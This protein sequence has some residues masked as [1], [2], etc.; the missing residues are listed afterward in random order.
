MDEN[1][2]EMSLG[3]FLRTTRVKKGLNQRKIAESMGITP[4]Y[5]C[6]LE[7][8][9]HPAATGL[10]QKAVEAYL[11]TEEEK[12]TFHNLMV[13]QPQT[14]PKIKTLVIA[15]NA[16]AVLS[17]L[18]ALSAEEFSWVVDSALAYKKLFK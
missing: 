13:R 16:T 17:A 1:N 9:A 11:M 12:D 2:Q 3:E 5:V 14:L 8:S 7:K 4:S 18:L 15:P 10:Y 6:K